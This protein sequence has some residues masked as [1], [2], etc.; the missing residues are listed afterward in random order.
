VEV[1]PGGDLGPSLYARPLPLANVV[2]RALAIASRKRGIVSSVGVQTH[3][4]GSGKSS[5]FAS[6]SPAVAFGFFFFCSTRL[7][8]LDMDRLMREQSL[9]ACLTG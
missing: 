5:S 1:L 4:S 2:G 9:W 3:P 6:T 8:P 7:G